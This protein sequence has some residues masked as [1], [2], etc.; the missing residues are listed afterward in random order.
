MVLSSMKVKI[1]N[2]TNSLTCISE[3]ERRKI[4]G[5]SQKKWLISF[6]PQKHKRNTNVM[7]IEHLP[8]PPGKPQPRAGSTC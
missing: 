5:K 2:N 4:G 1:M 6:D 7:C 3:Q 8:F